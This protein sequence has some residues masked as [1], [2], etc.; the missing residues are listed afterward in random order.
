MLIINIL[1]IFL[2]FIRLYDRTNKIQI[3][4]KELK[5]EEVYIYDEEKKIVLL[6]FK[7]FSDLLYF[8]IN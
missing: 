6:R 2:Y 4:A 7:F 5:M 1:L 8:K 3:Y